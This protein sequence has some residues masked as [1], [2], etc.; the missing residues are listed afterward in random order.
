[1]NEQTADT[2]RPGAGPEAD[3]QGPDLDAPGL[4]LNRELSLLAFQERVLEE[5]EDPMN[6]LLERVKFLA[7]FSSNMAEFYM[8][9]VAGLKQQVAAGVREVSTDGLTP[10]EQLKLVRAE[11]LRLLER[12]RVLYRALKDELGAA[13]VHVMDY[14]ELD[15]AQRAAAD[16]YF[17]NNVFPVLTPLAFDP[18]R[19]FPHISNLSLNLAVLV[20]THDGEDRFARVKI[21]KT[22]PRLV[23]VCPPDG[24]GPVCLRS[25]GE[26]TGRAYHFVWLEQLVSAHLDTVFPGLDVIEAHPFRVTRDAE[27]SIQELEADDLLETIEEGVRRRRFGSVVRVTVTPDLPEFIAGILKD[28]L[29]LS[30]MDIVVLEPPIGASDLISLMA[31]DRPDLKDTPFK[32][33]LPPGFEE[34]EETD[35][36]A[37]IRERDILIHRPYESFEPFVML[38]RQAACDPSVLAIKMTLYRV[39]R[40]SPVVE[41]LLEAAENGKEVAVLVELKARF[42]EE[43]NIGW[44][45]KLE[46]EG[47]HVVYGLLGVKTHSKVGLIVRAEGDGLRRYLHVGTGN[48]NVWTATQYTDLDLL[49]DDELMGQD[50]SE[51]FN[52]LTGYAEDHDYERFLVAPTT[53][54]PEF[55]KLIEREIEHARAGRGGRLILKMNSLVDRKM[56]KL[57]YQASQAGVDVDLIVRGI[58]VL[59]PGMPGVSDNIRVRSIVGRFLEH[60]R[61]YYFANAGEPEVLIGSADIMGRNL[62]RRVEVLTPVLDPALRTRLHDSILQTYLADT[63]KARRMLPDGR[64]EPVGP[65]PGEEPLEAQEELIRLALRRAAD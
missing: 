27:V 44:A 25:D 30:D 46:H 26:T 43:S 10:A 14:G 15:D 2:A 8:V 11:A 38:L 1:M 50:A 45:K 56:V 28:N 61:I 22:L 16:A 35:M 36:F 63:V 4:Y 5:A 39:G 18:A 55:M 21:P 42:D 23:P 29:R 65:G 37:A 24:A 12:A 6:P 49:T 32:P 34:A 40:D 47:V 52:L 33:A 54:R 53:L 59:R 64:Y 58:C 7:I 48:Y 19:P 31:I 20:R 57:L 62:D 9:R 51:L 60:S 41:A 13:G 17:T 3:A